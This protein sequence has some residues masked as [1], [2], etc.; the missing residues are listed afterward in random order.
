MY[1][2]AVRRS[3]NFTLANGAQIPKLGFGT[4]KMTKEQATPAVAHAI[5]TGYRHIDCAWAYRNEDAVAAGIKKSG[6]P[7]EQLWITSKLWNS[8]H[9]PEHVEKALDATLKDLG[10]D[11]LDLYLMHWPV[12]FLNSKGSMIPSIR[13]TGGHPVESTDLSRD[14][15]ATYRVMEEMV[16]KGKVRN[17]GVSNFNIRRTGEVVDESSIKPVVNQVE[18]NLGVH[19]DELRNYAHAHGVTLQAYSPF[20]SSQNVAKYLEDD[21]VVDV[22]QRNNIT[23]A[24]VLLAWTLGRDI[25]PI[26]KSVTPERIEENFATLNVNLPE[27]EI[28]H[29]S[30]EAL[31]R[32]IE[33]TVDPTEG[34]AVTDEIFEDGVDQTREMELKGGAY[35]PPPAHESP[36]EHRL[37]PRNDPETP[38]RMFHTAAHP[39][40]SSSGSSRRPT[41]VQLQ[42][43]FFRSFSSSSRSAAV[44]EVVPPSA[45][46]A[47]AVSESSLL[48][49]T[50]QSA[51]ATPGLRFVD[52]EQSIQRETQ[53]MNMY[54]VRRMSTSTQTRASVSAAT[55]PISVTASPAL[56]ARTK[57]SSSS[58]SSRKYPAKKSFLYEKYLR[59]LTD[60]Q[61]VVVLQHNNLSVA[62]LAKVRS[63]I[64]ALKLPEGQT[65]K[66]SLTVVRAGLMKAVTRQ[67]ASNPA[68]EALQPAL[69][70]PI[71]LLTCETLTP[72]YLSALFNVVDRA[73]GHVPPRAPAMGA[74]FPET[75]VANPRLVPLAA[76]LEGN[77][78]LQVPQSR[79][80]G[81]IGS[82]DTLRAQIVGLLSSPGQQLAGVLSQASGQQLAMTLE[83]RKRDLEA[84]HFRASS[85]CSFLVAIRDA[86]A[87]VLTSDPSA[88]VFGEDVAFGGVF[89]STMNLSTTF[90]RDR[91]FNTPLT[92]QGIIGFAIGLADMGHT[93]IAEIQF[94]DYIFPAFDQLVNEA[95]KYNYRSGGQFNVGKLTVR[96]PCMGVGHGA[97][98]HSQSVEQFFMGVPGLK[99][100]VP[101]S[102]IQAKGLLRASV[103]DDNPVVFLEP[104]ILY[105]ASVEQV[106]MDD[107]TLPLSQAEIVRPGND[108]TLIS[109]GAPL[110]ACEEALALLANP[111]A[112]IAQHF[113]SSIRGA[114]VE[115]IDLRTILPW[116]RETVIKSVAKTGRCVIVHEAPVTA[117]VGAEIAAEVQKNCFLNLEAPITRVGGWDTP[118][119]HV[120]ELFYKPE[121]VR[122]ADALVKCLT[123]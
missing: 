111:P 76:V 34:W 121:A 120:G 3:A 123:F 61:M 112:S 17:I 87:H 51:L 16:K 78:L 82:L 93:A 89:R 40:A 106:P 115:L 118:F 35:V 63:D 101:R 103:A 67:L 64:A 12:A 27:D 45:S 28:K 99:V 39:L 10:T 37:E 73:L 54:T 56:A 105:R 65:A 20:G 52:G 59:L 114:N 55:S 84:K 1:A 26:T 13:S 60:S 38:S 88:L 107:F 2:S 8:F 102:P 97:L 110:Y 94:G 11:Y 14:F 113:P 21:V 57:A 70:G 90:G 50:S 23:P 104:K 48:R 69:S 5:K 86:Q 43:S 6:V 42:K 98:Y 81:R 36:A 22:A 62:E 18:V 19:N 68:M 79:D 119:P 30:N 41:A 29:L 85:C 31:S 49:T 72:A 96:A 15:M 83:G 91:V 100:V 9:D 7:R 25:I 75:A 24:Q 44:A 47:P 53:K 4:W 77:R 80:V 109:W 117:G 33:R 66:A 95:A 32:P 58:T 116:D 92:E 71:A 108:L 74:K 122:I 46:E